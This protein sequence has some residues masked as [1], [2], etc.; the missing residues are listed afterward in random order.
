MGGAGV[1]IYIEPICCKSSFLDSKSPV[2][3]RGFLP[4]RHFLE[5]I[6]P[7]QRCKASAKHWRRW[8]GWLLSSYL[9]S[10]K[11]MPLVLSLLRILESY[12]SIRAIR[13]RWELERDIGK[14]CDDL[15]D[16]IEHARQAGTP[17]G[18]RLAD[19]LR[20]RLLRSSGIEVSQQRHPA[21]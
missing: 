11:R 14:Y 6:S 9:K 19:K 7:T 16:R 10:P 15:E 5:C 3:T 17:D 12:L 8:P 20:D 21:P 1:K 18:D 2:P 4:L 13:A